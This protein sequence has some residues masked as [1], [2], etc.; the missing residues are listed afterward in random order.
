[1]NRI[2]ALG[3]LLMCVSLASADILDYVAAED[4]SFAWSVATERPELVSLDLTSQTWQGIPWTHQVSIHLPR[5][6]TFP[7]TCVLYITGGNFR[8]E[9]PEALLLSALAQRLGMPVAILWGIPNQPLFDGL[10]EDAL[11]AHTFVQATVTGDESW[12]LLFPMAKAVSRAMDAIT[13]YGEQAWDRVV[14]RYITTGASKR[15]WTTWF[16]AVVDPRVI[17]IAPMVYDNLDLAAQMRHQIAL[18]GE[19]SPSI[20]DYTELD[21][22]NYLQTDAGRHLG[23]LVDPYTYRER[24]TLPKLIINGA[25]DEYWGVDSLNIYRPGLVGEVNQLYLP[26]SSHGLQ[27]RVR[28]VNTLVAFVRA[29]AGDQPRP[30]WSWEHD[31][32]AGQLTLQVT[33]PTATNVQIW[34]ADSPDGR[35]VTSTW[36]SKEMVRNGGIWTGGVPSPQTGRR[37]LFGEATFPSDD[38][39]YTLS[40]TMRL[41]PAVD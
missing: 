30:E 25:S 7:D 11:I 3:V 41:V 13:A 33:A 10:T 1:M 31:I 40:T 23:Q 34:Y 26:N 5:T 29:V 39:P 32:G 6:V 27:D 20:H 36:H 17:A 8:P 9:Q 22:V 4:D 15:G 37:A 35:F 2:L 19:P 28:L 14:D 16:S 12:P 24:L 18:W 21:L 38:L